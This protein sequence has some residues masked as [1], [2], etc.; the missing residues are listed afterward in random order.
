MFTGLVQR[1]GTVRRLDRSGG[2][3]RI[4]L[5]FPRWPDPLA[6]GES[7]AVQGTCLTVAEAGADSFAADVLDETLDCTTLGTLAIGSR[8]NLERALQLTARLGGHIVSGHVDTV[9]RVVDLRPRGRDRILKVA[10]DEDSF[11]LVVRKGSVAL[12][13]VSLT[14]SEVCDGKGAFEVNLIPTTWEETSLSDRRVGDR[15]NVE[16]DVLG[17]YVDRLLRPASASHRITLDTLAAA[18]FPV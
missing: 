10:C 12:D 8:V 2:G 15:I 14:V 18:G 3:A 13:G 6:F 5:A 4:V 17:K 7:V 1:I 16:T 9:A 11:R